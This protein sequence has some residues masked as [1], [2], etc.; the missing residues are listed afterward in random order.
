[1]PGRAIIFQS[2]QIGAAGAIAQENEAFWELM[3][4]LDKLIGK[5]I[6]PMMELLGTFIEISIGDCEFKDSRYTIG[7]KSYMIILGLLIRR[8]LG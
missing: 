6:F 1:M 4:S 3:A 8:L 2:V 7:K 5:S